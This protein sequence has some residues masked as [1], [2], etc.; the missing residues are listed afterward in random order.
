MRKISLLG[1]SLDDVLALRERIQALF[2]H[3]YEFLV[4]DSE[5]KYIADLKA[6]M[7]CDIAFID[8]RSAETQGVQVA[9]K[10]NLIA[11]GTVIIFLLS[12]R[13]NRQDTYGVRHSL[14]L[15]APVQDAYLKKVLEKAETV[16]EN[17]Y[18]E[19]RL[20]KNSASLHT[21]DLVYIA[22]KFKR[23]VFHLTDGTTTVYPMPLSKI[24]DQLPPNFLRVHQSYC[25]NRD[26]IEFFSG[27]SLTLRGGDVVPVS[28][29]Y[30]KM[31]K[32]ILNKPFPAI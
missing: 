4:Y 14:L 26:Y 21:S 22:N 27:D 1:S 11:A 2:P 30:L 31:L 18:F 12:N 15:S 24:F 17:S 29:R 7:R 6:G 8:I 28:R 3:T 20:Q 13:D 25:V 5:S 16:L 10:I 19:I 23:S 32:E 9:Y